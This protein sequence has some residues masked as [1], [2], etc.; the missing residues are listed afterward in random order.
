MAVLQIVAQGARV[1]SGISRAG[2][3]VELLLLPE[4]LSYTLKGLGGP[5]GEVSPVRPGR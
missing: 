4:S 1:K 5:Q 2:A 3:T